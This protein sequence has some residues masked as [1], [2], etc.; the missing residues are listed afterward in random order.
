MSDRGIA[1]R[2][3]SDILMHMYPHITFSPC[4]AH[5]L[6]N[7]LKDIGKLSFVSPIIEKANKIV[8]FVRNHQFLRISKKM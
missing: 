6:N 2:G 1:N 4:M 7:L 3:T 5:C 8:S